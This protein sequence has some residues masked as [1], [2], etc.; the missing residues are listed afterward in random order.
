MVDPLPIARINRKTPLNHGDIST[1]PAEGL[2]RKPQVWEQCISKAMLGEPPWKTHW[3]LLEVDKNAIV[4]LVIS[5]IFSDAESKRFQ[6]YLTAVTSPPPIGAVPTLPRFQHFPL[7]IH[8]IFSPSPLLKETAVVT[9]DGK[10]QIAHSNHM[11]HKIQSSCSLNVGEQKFSNT[12]FQIHTIATIL[13]KSKH[14]KYHKLSSIHHPSTPTLIPSLIPSNDD[15]RP[16]GLPQLLKAMQ[17]F[18]PV[19]GCLR[20]A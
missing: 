19:G 4:I 18:L 20:V 5:A 1:I 15:I 17:S 13:Q 14:K 16:P 9:I 3:P 11:D 2:F 12:S 7:F 6:S 10:I 8:G